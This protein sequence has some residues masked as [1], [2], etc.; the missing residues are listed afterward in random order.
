MTSVLN[1][2]HLGILILAWFV[3]D[4][5]VP[6]MI[7]LGHRL[8]LL[9]RPGGHKA[10][11]IPIPFFGGIA[12]FMGF[13][14]AVGS[15]LRFES[16]SNFHPLVGMLFGGVVVITLGLIDDHRPINAVIKLVALFVTTLVLSAFGVQL[17]LFPPVF[18]DIPNLLV[19]LLWIVGVTS[20]LN[21][22]D[23]TDG[24]APG[25]A[26]IAGIFIFIIAWGS[27][28]QDAQHWLSYLAV[29]MVGSCL[30]MLRYNFPPARIY[31][32]DNG[33][34]FVGYMLAVMLVFA[35]YS[36]SPVKA[37]FVPGL[38]LS[39]PIFDIVLVTILRIRD[40]DVSSI[41]EA[42][43]YCGR[44]HIAHLLM[45]LGLTKRQSVLTMYGL[46]IIGGVAA[47][48]V[49]ISP[50]NAISLALV[51]MYFTFLVAIGVVLGRTRPY[52]L[53]R[54]QSEL[55]ENEV[56][57]SGLAESG[58]SSEVPPTIEWAKRR[59]RRLDP[60]RKAAPTS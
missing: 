21:S 38:I 53:G 16:L 36:T 25:L 15:T 40:R 44:D 28:A 1:Y 45:G 41:R 56:A 31:L 29:G 46:G 42:I 52:V 18:Y 2:P 8:K 50:S 17:D 27:S 14:L 20:A 6:I 5:A 12:I 4:L 13:T 47:L 7:K 51:G 43:L 32:G 22:V 49:W 58:L 59:E 57:A 35:H 10:Q 39:V 33:S 23:N 48:L 3:A 60:G 34:F 11:K 30:G 19:T 24:V 9:D 26:A 54:I 37:I 55:P